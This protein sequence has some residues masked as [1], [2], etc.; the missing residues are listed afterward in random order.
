MTMHTN[1]NPPIKIG[2]SRKNP[3]CFRP[4]PKQTRPA[5]PKTLNKATHQLGDFRFS[6]TL[7]IS[8]LA[9]AECF[10]QAT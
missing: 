2:K 5:I 10:L 3:S 1:T 8:I 9:Q 6:S 4:K 7:F